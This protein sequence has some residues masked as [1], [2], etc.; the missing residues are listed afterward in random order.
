MRTGHVQ[1]VE[2]PVVSCRARTRFSFQTQMPFAHRGSVIAGVLQQP[3]KRHDSV[4]ETAFVTQN[5]EIKQSD[6][7]L[8]GHAGNMVIIAAQ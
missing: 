8:P 2:C 3:R 4:R 1:L 7:A 6:P 5:R